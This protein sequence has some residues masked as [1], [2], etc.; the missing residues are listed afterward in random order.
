MRRKKNGSLLQVEVSPFWLEK[1]QI[2][3]IVSLIWKKKIQLVILLW[4]IRPQH[5]IHLHP[6]RRIGWTNRARRRL[7]V[8][9]VWLIMGV[10]CP[11]IGK[12][13]DFRETKRKVHY[14]GFN[15]GRSLGEGMPLGC[16]RMISWMFRNDERVCHY[17]VSHRRL[18]G[19][20]W[21]LLWIVIFSLW[22]LLVSTRHSRLGSCLSTCLVLVRCF[23]LRDTCG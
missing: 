23:T 11:S 9:L 18:D 21:Y 3:W 8:C 22:L 15:S 12:I 17:C 19:C 16:F 14:S 1:L 2:Y 6:K 4:E 20:W 10:P 7:L 5:M 13:C